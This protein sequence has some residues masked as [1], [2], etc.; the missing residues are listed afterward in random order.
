MMDCKQLRQDFNKKRTDH[1]IG[2]ERGNK[3]TAAG[4]GAD[5]RG[6]QNTGEQ[7]DTDGGNSSESTGGSIRDEGS[8]RT[9]K[10]E[11]LKNSPQADT[12]L[13]FSRALCFTLI[14]Q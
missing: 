9:S 1:E 8:E 7:R 6:N 5:R 3:E 11:V 4:E 2:Y 14:M 10:S 12:E 13:P